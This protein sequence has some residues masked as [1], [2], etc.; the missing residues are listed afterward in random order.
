M[1]WRNIDWKKLLLTFEG[2]IDRTHF[3]IG[4]GVATAISLVGMVVGMI[5]PRVGSILALVFNLVALVPSVAVGLKRLHDRDKDWH[6][7]LV[8]YL[9]PVALP[10]AVGFI[11]LSL[12]LPAQLVALGL[13][14]WCIYE[15]GV[16]KGTEGPNRYGPPPP[17]ALPA[18][19]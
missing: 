2:R 11:S 7:L 17:S 13:V 18:T 1:N 3:W 8:F 12:L 5:V 14:G 4:I 16:Q 10:L 6:W 15:L 9:L 19:A